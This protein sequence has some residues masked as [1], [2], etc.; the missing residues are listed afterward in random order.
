MFMFRAPR[1]F[2]F[3]LRY[4]PDYTVSEDHNFTIRL[5]QHGDIVSLSDVLR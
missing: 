3:E 2:G 1:P 4:N 5:V